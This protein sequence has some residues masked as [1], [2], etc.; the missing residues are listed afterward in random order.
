MQ[1]ERSLPDLVTDSFKK[2]GRYRGSTSY[3]NHQ[4]ADLVSIVVTTLAIVFSVFRWDL[5]NLP[6]FVCVY[7]VSL[8]L[9]TILF[10]V[11]VLPPVCIGYNNCKCQSIPYANLSSNY[12]IPKIALI[13]TFAMGLFLNEVPQCGDLTMSGH[14]VYIWALIR[15]LFEILDKIFCG[16]IYKTIKIV[17]YSTVCLVLVTI[18][19][20]RNHYTID[21]ILGS[22]FTNAIWE[23]YSKLQIVRSFDHQFS[24]SFL[25]KFINWMEKGRKEVISEVN[26]PEA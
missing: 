2:Y 26:S 9:R 13:Y 25:G 19:M 3:M 12:S 16:K 20:I 24:S 18:V 4:P 7:A 14:T 6:K 10:S 8:H 5:V 1:V 11:T 15:Y 23:L 22:V 21:I 17:V